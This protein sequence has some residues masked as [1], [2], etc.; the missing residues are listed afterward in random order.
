GKA[1]TDPKAVL[2]HYARQLGVKHMVQG[3][4]YGR[5]TFPDGKDRSEETLFQRYGLLFLI[6]SGMSQGIE[7]SDSTGRA[8]P[9][10]GRADRQQASVICANGTQKV[11]GESGKSQDYQE[12]HCGKCPRSPPERRR[13]S[14][15]PGGPRLRAPAPRA[16]GWPRPPWRTP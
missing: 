3:H 12:Q 10:A 9:I 8:L 14:L 13:F 1:S 4:Q 7:E 15:C 11:L 2:L 5:V 16:T 6:D